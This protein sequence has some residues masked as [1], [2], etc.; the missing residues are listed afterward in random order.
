MIYQLTLAQSYS[1]P[2]HLEKLT[3]YLGA[4]I[5]LL[6]GLLL[7]LGFGIWWAKKLWFGRYTETQE[8]RKATQSILSEYAT[9]V[10][11]HAHLLDSLNNNY[12]D[13]LHQVSERD[14]TIADLKGRVSSITKDSNGFK[15]SISSLQNSLG[16]R[17]NEIEKLKKHQEKLD[18]LLVKHQKLRERLEVGEVEIRNQIQANRNLIDPLLKE[19]MELDVKIKEIE[20]AEGS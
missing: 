8:S 4:I 10:D 15:G 6:L 14:N 17:N 16:D 13:S 7:F 20:D 11:E 2:E 5:P 19:W 1:F 9:T 12:Q 18:D 3:L